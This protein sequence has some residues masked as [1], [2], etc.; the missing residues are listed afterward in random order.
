MPTDNDNNTGQLFKAYTS[1]SPQEVAGYYDSWAEDYETH[2][3]NVGY[4][5][6]AMVAGLALRHVP[7]GSRPILDAGAGTGIMAQILVALGYPEIVGFDGS[8]DMLAGAAA[9][10][11]YAEL[12]QMY[13][14]QPLAYPDDHFQ[15]AVSAGVFTQGHAPLAGLDELVRVVCPGGCI[16]FSVARVYLGSSFQDK[17]DELKDKGLWCQIDASEHYDSTPLDAENVTAQVFAFKIN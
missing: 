2:M 1:T 12:D 11:V 15:A 5:H 6:P 7:P 3:S 9:K 10:N 8:K 17:S 13:L 14:G 4:L 16:I